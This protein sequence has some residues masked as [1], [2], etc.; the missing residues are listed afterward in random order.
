MALCRKE[1]AR[2]VNKARAI[3]IRTIMEPG[4]F[5]VLPASVSKDARGEDV[6]PFFAEHQWVG[7]VDADGRQVGRVSARQVFKALARCTPGL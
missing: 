6:L 1:L 7:T 3:H 5:D 4:E 2:E